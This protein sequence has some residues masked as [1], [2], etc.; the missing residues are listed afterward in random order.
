MGSTLVALS[1][2]ASLLNGQSKGLMMTSLTC[3]FLLSFVLDALEGIE[4][5][6]GMCGHGG[7]FLRNI[8]QTKGLAY[9]KESTITFLSIL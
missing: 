1:V 9:E 2:G 7:Y 5:I 3:I 6:S 4:P 8:F